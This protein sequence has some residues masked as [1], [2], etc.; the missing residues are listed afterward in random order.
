MQD[1]LAFDI[2]NYTI[3]DNG[4]V[5]ETPRPA[6]SPYAGRPCVV[7][8]PPSPAPRSLHARLDVRCMAHPRRVAKVARQIERE[9]GNML[10]F[11]T[12]LREAVCPERRF[13]ADYALSG[14]AS[15]TEVV[16][17]GDLQVAKVYISVFSDE[18]GKRVAMDNLKQ[19]E[20]YVRY[21]VGQAMRLRLVPEIRFYEARE[22]GGFTC[23]GC[24][25]WGWL[26]VASPRISWHTA[27][28]AGA[29]AICPGIC[30]RTRR[31][32]RR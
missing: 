11:D 7:R 16:L 14:I 9:I 2:F 5:P 19:L 25:S 31:S 24:S 17:S 20:G 1:P 29:T 23:L 21:N 22:I 4:F 28:G 30:C 18:F 8:L 13:G 3:C 10:L 6:P 26:L 15:V 32:R 27:C 12:R